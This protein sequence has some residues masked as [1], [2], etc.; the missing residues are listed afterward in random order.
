MPPHSRR[1]DAPL[2]QLRKAYGKLTP[3]QRQQLLSAESIL[4]DLVSLAN[5]ELDQD[6]VLPLVGLC[7][8]FFEAQMRSS[9]LAKEGGVPLPPELVYYQWRELPEAELAEGEEL[10][11][12]ARACKLEEAQRPR[13]VRDPRHD[14]RPLHLCESCAAY[15]QPAEFYSCCLRDSMRCCRTCMLGRPKEPF[16][17]HAWEEQH[18]RKA[19]AVTDAV[20]ELCSLRVQHGHKTQP[21]PAA[22]RP[23]AAEPPASPPPDPPSR[24]APMRHGASRA[25]RVGAPSAPARALQWAGGAGYSLLVLAIASFSS[26]GRLAARLAASAA[27]TL[28]GQPPTEP[29]A[30]PAQE[31]PVRNSEARAAA[32]RSRRAPRASDSSA[33]S[34]DADSD[35]GG[36]SIETVAAAAK[37]EVAA[38]A[39]AEARA[40]ARTGVRDA[41]AVRVV[42]GATLALLLPSY[43]EIAVDL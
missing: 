33:A 20:L 43:L 9:D 34:S 16:G 23:A 29:P 6:Y 17:E 41:V 24:P 12:I 37:A 42:L 25:P 2:T 11:P 28:V 35:A 30:P 19:L 38:K 10:I 36:E 1:W 18:T 15:K 7:A 13:D 31:R 22:P 5:G 39:E 8:A 27:A 32:R 21:A 26:L 4:Q 40:D 14:N 3:E